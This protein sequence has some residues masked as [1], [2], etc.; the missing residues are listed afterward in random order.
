VP[1][2]TNMPHKHKILAVLLLSSA[3]A[4][5]SPA[6]RRPPPDDQA[7]K[8]LIE[9]RTKMFQL[10]DKAR[11]DIGRFRAL[12]DQDG[13]PLVGNVANKSGVY[14][15]SELCSDVRKAAKK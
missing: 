3:S 12:C 11:S 10:R 4:L 15:P 1:K 9:L 5:A 7:P 13:Y 2:E 8:Q 14:Q 6:E